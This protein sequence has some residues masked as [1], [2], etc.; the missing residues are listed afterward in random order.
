M[1]FRY[2]HDNLCRLIIVILI[3][4][5]YF[6]V[7]VNRLLPPYVEAVVL[8]VEHPTSLAVLCIAN[9]QVSIVK[10]T[11]TLPTPRLRQHTNCVP[12]INSKPHIHKPNKGYTL[13]LLYISNVMIAFYVDYAW[14]PF[15]HEAATY[16]GFIFIKQCRWGWYRCIKC[17]ISEYYGVWK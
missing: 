1:Y 10:H 16:S 3:S 8:G 7:K 9:P 6:I 11:P 4:L 12:A 15:A 17:V 2:N 13:Q 5:R 14:N